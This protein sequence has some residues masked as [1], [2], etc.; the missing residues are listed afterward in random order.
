MGGRSGDWGP[1]A[2]ERALGTPGAAGRGR[3][4]TGAGPEPI[5]ARVCAERAGGAAARAIRADASG[6]G[7]PGSQG[8]GGEEKARRAR[9][10]SGAGRSRDLAAGWEAAS[11]PRTGRA[12]GA[13]TMGEKP[14]TR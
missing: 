6:P 4:G 10:R 8:G 3:G 2:P 1:R 5:A 14:G 7:S 11:E 13:R 9:V 12:A